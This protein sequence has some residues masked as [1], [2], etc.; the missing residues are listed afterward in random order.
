MVGMKASTR[1]TAVRRPQPRQAIPD[2]EIEEL[3]ERLHKYVSDLGMKESFN[4][5]AYQNLGLTKAADGLSLKKKQQ[6][7]M[8]MLHV[9]PLG[10][11]KY[12]QLREGCKHVLES[13]GT[14][15]FHT[16][17]NIAESAVPGKV[18]D[19]LYIMLAH[20]RR[21]MGCAKRW[22]ETFGSCFQGPDLEQ[23]MYMRD[24]MV[25]S[26]FQIKDDSSSTLSH[27]STHEPA[28]P[29]T[30]PRKICRRSSDAS[31]D[32]DG[33]AKVPSLVK[34]V[35]NTPLKD[36]ELDDILQES[37][38]PVKKRP[39]ALKAVCKSKE[40]PMKRPAAMPMKNIAVA[41][42]TS[43]TGDFKVIKETMKVGGGKHQSYIQHIPNGKSNLQLVASISSKMV[44]GKGIG[45][46]QAADA[47]LK[48]VKCQQAPTKMQVLKHRDV[49]L[50]SM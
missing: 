13:F 25:S 12:S 26:G 49:L 9:S 24:F 43:K 41:K 31:V 11:I 27:A 19:Q 38:P 7:I 40:Q 18:A 10:A 3:K 36:P 46:R 39:A 2:I 28:L 20:V 17:K 47:L 6:L 1:S 21:V 8:C 22:E 15:V 5:Y 33:F 23:W 48:W 4:L 42:S 35:L 37:P 29:L 16:F 34:S 30:P 14:E 45:H 32:S 44:D 50:K